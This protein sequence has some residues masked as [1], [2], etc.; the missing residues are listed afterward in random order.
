MINFLGNENRTWVEVVPLISIQYK[1]LQT[2]VQTL[3]TVGDSWRRYFECVTIAVYTAF[4]NERTS[5]LD[6]LWYKTILYIQSLMF[7]VA[8]LLFFF[9]NLGSNSGENK[10]KYSVLIMEF[11]I[12]SIII[13]SD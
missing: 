3:I 12:I 7:I 9:F 10:Y 8:A 1:T 5:I 2:Q 6:L 13:S 4:H 11:L